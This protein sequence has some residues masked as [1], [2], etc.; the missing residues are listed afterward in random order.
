MKQAVFGLIALFLLWSS[1]AHATAIFDPGNHPQQPGEEN[2]LFQGGETGL[3]VTGITNQSHLAVQFASSTDILVETAAGQ[4]N[5]T[6]QDGLLN[7]ITISVPNGSF[8]DLIFNPLCPTPSPE[9]CGSATVTAVTN[10]GTFTF[11]YPGG[12]GNGNNFLT[13]LAI[14]GETLSSVTIDAAGFEDLRQV[15][16]SG[17]TTGGNPVPEP[18]TVILLGSGLLGLVLWGRKKVQA[19]Q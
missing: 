5:L 6:A 9:G 2:I 18:S 12:L 13:I 15:R 10:D 4:A 1:A 17:A 8:T 14:N 16:I 7:N 11:T 19:Q 3:V